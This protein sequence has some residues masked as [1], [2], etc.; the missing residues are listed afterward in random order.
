MEG[1]KKAQMQSA[2]GKY[3]SEDVMQKV[4]KNI[5]INTPSRKM[6]S[7]FFVLNHLIIF[8]KFLIQNHSYKTI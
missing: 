5:V 7:I 1:E 6:F 3:L 8:L 4:V 2:M